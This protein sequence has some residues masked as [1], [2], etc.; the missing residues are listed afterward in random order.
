MP[1][2]MIV[3][4][5]SLLAACT[6]GGSYDA[7]FGRINETG[8]PEQHAIHDRQLRVMMARMNALLQERFMTETQRDS[9]RRRYAQRLADSAMSLS[10][11]VDS[12]I[13]QM[14]SLALTES[15]QVAFL[16]LAN[17]LREQS[18]QLYD[19][20]GRERLDKIDASLSELKTTCT[21]CHAMFRGD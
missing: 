13:A 2:T 21:S 3:L 16:A 14:P 11:T 19:L 6:E 4:T 17:K 15:E 20:A 5:A 8:R 9:E 7:Q 10:E 18:G 12:I 1:R